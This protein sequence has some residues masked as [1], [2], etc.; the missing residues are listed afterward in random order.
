MSFKGWKKNGQKGTRICRKCF[1]MDP[2]KESVSKKI[3]VDKLLP[4][5]S[6][7]GKA[8]GCSHEE[9]TLIIYR[10]YSFKVATITY[11]LFVFLYS[12]PSKD[13]TLNS[14]DKK[15]KRIINLSELGLINK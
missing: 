5:S 13:H 6:K 9:I 14:C 4:L 2:R 15:R 3:L 12:H 11:F 8:S 10:V 1:I 7:Q